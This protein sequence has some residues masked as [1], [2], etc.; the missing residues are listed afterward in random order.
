MTKIVPALRY[1]DA[2][3]AIDWLCQAFGFEQH[4][5][6][7]GKPGTV[8]HAELSLGDQMIMLGSVRESEF[9]KYMALPLDIGG[10]STVTLYVVVNDPDSHHARALSAGAKIIREPVDQNYGGRD[11][12]CLDIEGH[13]WS[14][15]TYDPWNPPNRGA[16]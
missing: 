3:K 5:V 13:V 10:R 15:G 2:P 7:S 16:R 12:S 1:R 6:V 9:D 14:F 4:I 11:Y 8:E